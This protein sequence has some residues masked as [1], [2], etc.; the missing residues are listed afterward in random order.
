MYFRPAEW[1]K[2]KIIWLAWP[3]DRALWQEDLGPAQK[4]FIAL[5]NSLKN[6][7]LVILFP[8][9]QELNQ[10]SLD[11]QGN[12][13]FKVMPY[14]DI[15][16]RDTMPIFVKDERGQTAAVLPTFNGWGKKYLFA[17]DE[18]L[19]ARVSE[20]LM[21]QKVTTSLI[22]EGGS[23]EC[24]GAGTMLTTE[25]CLLN[26]N[27]S[28]LDKK[29][30]EKEF[31]HL[32]GAKKVI[33]LKEGLIND[34]TDGH[35]DTI[36]R[37]LGPNKIAIM[38]PKKGDPNYEILLNIKKT[39]EKETDALGRKFELVEV[40]SPGAILNRHQEL[41]PASY[42]NFLMGD[43]VM[44][45]PTY[46]SPEDEEAVHILSDAVKLDV[47]GL[48]AKSILSGGGA[49]HCISQEYYR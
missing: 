5:V 31:A 13:S 30:I 26:K 48:K 21:M 11:L 49:F 27:R 38:V 3:Y 42:L 2:G 10:A 16:L 22:F 47:V 4:E 8:N 23:I 29:A 32:F 17:D 6:E 40:P 46:E 37:F 1:Q 33:W 9:H 36:A 25:Q 35:I 18:S 19:S 34:H 14:G 41:M 12:I 43:E 15:W 28:N 7:Q 39:L 44:V 20:F 24:D 45:V